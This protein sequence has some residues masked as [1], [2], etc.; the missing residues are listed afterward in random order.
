MTFREGGREGE[1]GV[2]RKAIWNFPGDGWGSQSFREGKEKGGSGIARF[3]GSAWKADIL[4]MLIS[5]FCWKLILQPGPLCFISRSLL[6]F[7]SGIE[8]I[9][10]PPDREPYLVN[11]LLTWAK[12]YKTWFLGK[13]LWV[14]QDGQ[15]S[16]GSSLRVRHWCVVFPATPW[17]I[18]NLP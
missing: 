2:E 3:G 15:C 4:G 12:F 1:V 13:A 14:G 10:T 8:A 17:H 6:A 11:D 16:D 9:V 18:H 5:Y 7:K